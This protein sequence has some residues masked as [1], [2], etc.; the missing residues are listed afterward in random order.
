MLIPIMLIS[1]NLG[2]TS[3]LDYAIAGAI[4]PTPRVAVG[5]IKP[6]NNLSTYGSFTIIQRHQLDQFLLLF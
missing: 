2:A 6:S 4:M 3:K 5:A 1:G